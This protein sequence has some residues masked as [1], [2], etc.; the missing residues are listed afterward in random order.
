VAEI[1]P[2]RKK[3][4]KKKKKTERRLKKEGKRVSHVP[5]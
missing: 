3:K 1:N 2:Q 5:E 4:K